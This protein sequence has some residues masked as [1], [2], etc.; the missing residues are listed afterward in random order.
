MCETEPQTE[1]L[2]NKMSNNLRDARLIDKIET[3]ELKERRY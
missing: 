2:K 1:R 3:E